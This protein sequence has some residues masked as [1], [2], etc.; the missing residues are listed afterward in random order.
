MD[1]LTVHQYFEYPETVRPME[2]VYGFVR[3]PAMPNYEHQ[4]IAT[5]LLA[6]MYAHVMQQ[7]TGEVLAPMDVVLDEAAALVVQP[8]I[9][10][11]SRDRRGI[12]KER[13]WGPPDLVVEILSPSTARRD[14][15]VKVGWYRKHG[16]RECWLVDART[17]G[18]EVIEFQSSTPSRMF[19]GPE[20]LRSAV[21]PDLNIPA[22]QIFFS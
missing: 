19:R 14:R 8:D 20:R 17:Q 10:F 21:L 9:V 2:L 12:I 1:K 4:R 13:I 6:L 22:E 15:T 16:V 5:R 7:G 11:V 18:V 3:E